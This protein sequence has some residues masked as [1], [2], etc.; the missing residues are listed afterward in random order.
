VSKEL[1]LSGKSM[2]AFGHSSERANILAAD[3]LL[4]PPPGSSLSVVR[5]LWL[6]Y[7]IPAQAFVLDGHLLKTR[8]PS[9]DLA[10]LCKEALR[11]GRI[12]AIPKM[13][14]HVFEEH[15]DFL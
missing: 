6:F 11:S 1:P 12:S 13:L 9:F 3:L 15:F 2:T 14:A 5:R 7:I 10:R 4:L 8:R